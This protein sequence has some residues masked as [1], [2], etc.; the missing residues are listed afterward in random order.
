[1][2]LQSEYLEEHTSNQG[3]VELL[4]VESS[5][6]L[7]LEKEL[8]DLKPAYGEA[9]KK[10]ETMECEM[11]ELRLASTKQQISDQLQSALSPDSFGSE[12]D[13]M[14]VIQID[15]LKR[16]NES[17]RQKL[18]QEKESEEEYRQKEKAYYENKV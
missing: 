13:M 6:R 1:M 17:L 3:T 8:D 15:K 4:E 9:L 18:S 10:L 7:R 16:E 5:E 12:F 14:T 11:L 2:T